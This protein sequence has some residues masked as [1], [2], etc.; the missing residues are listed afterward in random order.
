MKL[1]IANRG[2]IALRIIRTCRKLGINTALVFSDADR[3]S[4]P[5]HYANE[6]YRLQGSTPAETYLNI[7]KIIKAAADTG[8]DA[9]HPGYGFLAEDASFVAACEEN[10]LTFVG[11]PRAALEKLGN[12]LLARTTMRDANVPLIPGSEDSVDNEDEAVRVAEGVGLPVI[13]KA[14]YGGGGRGMR[15]AK[16]E[17][18]VRRFF[19][20][21][22]LES[23]SAFGRDMLYIEKQ[24]VDPRH[25]EV[26][27][28]SDS[29]GKIVTLG[30][31]ECSIQRRHQKLVEE[32]PSTA[33]DERLRSRLNNAAKKGLAAAGYVNAGTVEFLLDKSGNFYFL[34]VNKRL[35]VEHLVTELTTGVDLVEEQLKIAS[36]DSLGLSQNEIQVKGWA[37]NCRIN[38][39]DPRRGFTPSPGTVI[40]FHPPTGPGIRVDSALYPGYTIPEF[41]DSM[42][43]KLA[44]WGRDRD[45][46]I[47]RLRVALDEME[48]VGVP[49]TLSLHLA[50]M[51]DDGFLTGKFDTNYLDRVLPR[52]NMDLL[53]TERYAVASA[54]ASKMLFPRSTIREATASKSRWRSLDRSSS[55]PR[56][57]RAGA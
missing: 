11:P 41:Y 34:E 20:I 7:P 36:G 3:E 56:D 48:I 14:V 13:I 15:V 17:E 37:I 54:V 23:A 18:E 31:R 43:A 10:G 53:E 32:A 30:E 16:T 4:L 5:L 42:V 46:A 40:S 45:E 44:S 55:F 19:R 38:A 39:E 21:T 26:Q 9:I 52:M 22:K 29:Q 28:L 1:L 8:C 57:W 2:E 6:R 12:K 47:R 25:I 49:T 33:A 50:I 24:L 27:A 35:Q 51:N